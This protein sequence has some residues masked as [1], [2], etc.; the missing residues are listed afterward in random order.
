VYFRLLAES[1]RRGSRRKLLAATAVALGVLAATAVAE[2]L[3]AAGD[4]LARELGS[5]GAN[6]VVVPAAGRDTFATADLGKLRAIFWRNNIVAAAPLY[7]LRVR[8][9]PAAGGGDGVVAP[10]VGTWFDQAVDGAWRSGLP[11]TRPTLRVNGRWPADGAEEAVIGRRLAARLGLTTGEAA[12]VEIGGRRGRLAVVGV[13]VS[14]GEEE[15]EAFAP[16]SAVRALAGGRTTAGDAPAGALAGPIPRAEVF[17]LTN[18]E[19]GNVRDPKTMAPKEYDRWYCTAYPS[20]IA[21]QIDEAMPDAHAEVVRGITAATADLA[22]RLRPVL[23]ALAA[24]ALAG[25]AVGVTSVMTA[26]VLE[27]RLEAGLAVALGAEG[28]KVSL[29]F[30]SEAALLGAAGGL[31]GGL[32]GLAAGRLLGAAVFGVAVPWTPVL[33]PLAVAT[34]LALAVV[35][36]LPAVLRPLLHDPAAVLKRATA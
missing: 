3:L 8:F 14:G 19:A 26:T 27:R 9:S 29:F 4:R 16:L 30:L 31:A 35:G 5:Y 32:A 23:A 36:S 28:W 13:V 18:P 2:L 24:V 33:L 6:L 10:L 11:R 12:E 25:A 20:S 21:Y 22:G 15:D 17:A 1:L 7:P 34:G